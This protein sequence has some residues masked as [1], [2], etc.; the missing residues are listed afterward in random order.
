MSEHWGN[1]GRCGDGG[2]HLCPR[3]EATIDGREDT[4]C[5][6]CGEGHS[7]CPEETGDNE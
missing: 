2:G 3:C 5:D 1:C 7:A 4:R 6:H